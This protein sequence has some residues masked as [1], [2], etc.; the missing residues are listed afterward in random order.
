MLILLSSL[1][2]ALTGVAPF[3][4]PTP[5]LFGGTLLYTLR[6]SG[7]DRR[8][9]ILAALLVVAGAGLA[10]GSA[11]VTARTGPESEIDS[12][13]TG[14][15]VVIT[16]V[17]V[18]RRLLHHPVVNVSTVAGALCIYLLLGV[19]FA[20][21]F[22]FISQMWIGPF[23]ASTARPRAVDFIYFSL[24]TLTTLSYGDVVPRTDIAR[25]LAVIA[26][27][28]G[29]MY[30]VTVVAL[31]VSSSAPSVAHSE[32]CVL[33]GGSPVS[34]ATTASG[35]STGSRM[36]LAMN[37]AASGT[38]SWSRLIDTSPR[39][40]NSS[41]RG[42]RKYSARVTWRGCPPGVASRNVVRFTMDRSAR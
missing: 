39:M 12:G 34:V 22:G 3:A 21:F 14:L 30:T 29:Q 40:P 19:F 5:I 24:S 16:R 32:R 1:V 25:M 17:A 11:A 6:T 2:T 26:A 13:V 28:F 36:A 8:R 33:S 9:R 18:G 10:I 31:L 4:I 15:L 27:L 23:F 20:F 41:H 7:V 35:R 38:F 42:Q 37:R